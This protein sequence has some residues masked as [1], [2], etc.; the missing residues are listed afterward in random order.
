MERRF[1]RSIRIG[2]GAPQTAA[3]PSDSRLFEA[4]KSAF[5]NGGEPKNKG[6]ECSVRDSAGDPFM[7]L[8]QNACAHLHCP[9][10]GIRDGSCAGPFV[11]ALQ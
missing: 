9:H 2:L 8:R 10:S 5:P 1:T 7:R 6:K 11:F 4:L 3:E